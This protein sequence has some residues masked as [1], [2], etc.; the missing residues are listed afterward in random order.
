MPRGLD[1]AGVEDALFADRPGA[2]R[3]L[4]IDAPSPVALAAGFELAEAQAV[5][6]RATKV[7]AQVRA[8]DAGA[9]GAS[10]AR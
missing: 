2:Q 3:L 4:A 7:V 6:L 9:T 5:L 8:A 1:G 10:S